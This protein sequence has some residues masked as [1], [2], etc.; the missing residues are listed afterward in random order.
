MARLAKSY[1]NHFGLD[2]KSSDIVRDPQFASG[3]KNAEYKKNGNISKREGYRCRAGDVGGSGLHSYV[4]IDRVTAKETE[5]LI[6]VDDNLHRLVENTVLIQYTGAQASVAFNLFFDKTLG[7]YKITIVEGTVTVL[8]Y[9]LGTGIDE[10]TPVSLADVKATIEGISV[11]YSVTIT[12]DSTATAAFLDFARDKNLSTDDLTLVGRSW[13]QIPSPI[14]LLPGNVT[15]QGDDDYYL[16]TAVQLNNNLYLSN[17]YDEMI[18]YDGQNAYRAGMPKPTAAPLIALGGAGLLNPTDPAGYRYSYL[19]TQIDANLNEVAGIM[20]DETAGISPVNQT[21]DI[22]VDNINSTSGFNTNAG[23]VAGAQVGVNTITVDDGAGGN[24]TFVVGDT[25]YFFDGVGGNYVEREILSVTATTITIDGA[26]VDVIDNA[27]ISNNLRISIYRNLDGGVFQFLVAEIPNNPFVTTQVYNDNIVD[28][29]LGIQYILPLFFHNLPPKGRFISAY[30][31]QMY[32]AGSLEQPS[33][34]SWSA[35]EGPEYWEPNLY[36]LRM[37]SINGDKITGIK[38]SNEVMTVFERRAMH[39]ISGDI[40]NNNVRVDTITRDIGCV[41]HNSIQ[42]VRGSLY[43]L[44]DRGVWKSTSG[45]LPVQVS[46]NIEPEFDKDPLLDSN[47]EPVYKRAIALNDREKEQYILYIPSESTNGGGIYANNFSTIFVED[48][49][50]GAWLSWTNMNM[51]GGAAIFNDV[52]YFSEKRANSNAGF[53]PISNFLFGKNSRGDNWDYQD[54]LVP[55]DFEYSTAWYYFGEPSI[56][57]KF[58]RLK[59]FASEETSNNSFV[60]NTDIEKNFIDGFVTASF[61]TDFTGNG[62]GYGISPYGDS[63]YGDLFFPSRKCKIGPIKAT[64]IR[65]VMKNNNPCE[66]VDILGW[67]LEVAMPYRQEIK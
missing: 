32:S 56:F 63:P 7:V 31:N 15:Y 2:L 41:S 43:F 19:Y 60:I 38:Q 42:E 16:T 10:V 34:V 64:S 26:A 22:T 9:S 61:V 24:H 6:A 1:I 8:D 5:V 18:K 27:V 39:V 40:P 12:G 67:E 51:A 49:Y 14:T 33:T 20:S 52:A 53:S 59:T 57:K 11:D 13:S 58:I 66:N 23:I 21:V 54:N 28:A 45:Q 17:G 36:S 3:M 46:K 48:Y 30:N 50:R 35:V 29:S 37:Q 65:F 44:S 4:S 47:Q 25:A 62:G 55:V